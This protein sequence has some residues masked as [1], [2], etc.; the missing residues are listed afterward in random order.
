MAMR[1]NTAGR[2][3]GGEGLIRSA[4]RRVRG[5]LW[6]TNRR[7]TGTAL[8]LVLLAVVSYFV[9]LKGSPTRLLQLSIFLALFAVIIT[10]PHLGIIALRV[11]RS[12]AAGLQ[13]EHLFRGLGVTLTK[14]IGLF[15]VVGFIALVVTKK[16]KPV[17]GHKSQLIF[18][19]G[20]LFATLISAFQA[21]AWKNV[22]TATFQLVENIV[23]YI[24]F[25]N[26]FAESKWFLRYTWFFVLSLLASCVTGIGSIFLS[27]VIRAAGAVGNPNGLAMVANFAAAMLLV[28]SLS[29][30]DFKRRLLALCGLGTCLITII[31]T[32]SRGGLLTIII[33]FTYQLVKRRKK[34]VPY[35]LAASLLVVALILIPEQYK[36][37]QQQWFGALFAGETEEALGGTRGFIYRSALD[38]FLKSPIIGVGPR[39]FGTIYQAEYAVEARG[40]AE[41][42]KAVHSGVLE[43]LVSTGILGFA[44]FLGLIIA[45][46]RLF[47]E[48]E[49]LC[50]GAGLGEYL[51]LNGMYEAL[52]IATIVA[53]SFETILRGGQ[54]FFVAIAAAAAVNRAAALFS[55]DAPSRVAAA[56]LAAPETANGAAAAR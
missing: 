46:Y 50:R 48:N 54:T 55:A 24:I 20:F 28:L 35:L 23:L 51:L 26:L 13:L 27:G 4:G 32:G 44:F 17:F 9:L 14:S 47:R 42:T 6:G 11:Y 8:A 33:T 31:F 39:T 2:Q 49:R 16:A 37:R 3:P 12:L 43:V 52:F 53:G 30:T 40:P 5:G 1:L 7:R 45:T 56:P 18:I 19:Y 29:V 36:S 34:L 38:V 21:L 10:K 22:W 25:V 15:T 41:H